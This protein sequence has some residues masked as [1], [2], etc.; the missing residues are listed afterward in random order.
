[1]LEQV[2]ARAADA[3][4]WARFERQLRSAGYCRRPVRLRGQTAAIDTQ[5]RV[6]LHARSSLV[7]TDFVVRL[8]DVD[9]HGVS[10][11]ICDGMVRKTSADPAMPDGLFNREADNWR[12]LFAIAEA[13]GGEWPRRAREAATQAAA[14]S[15]AASLVELLLGDIRDMFAKRKENR[16][17]RSDEIPSADLVGAMVAIDDTLGRSLGR[18]ASRSRRTG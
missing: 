4:Q 6:I 5:G 15:E 7:N 13:A 14:G 17:E 1:M 10:T 9:E 18:T 16:V 12:P 8:S 3:D 11:N 2:L